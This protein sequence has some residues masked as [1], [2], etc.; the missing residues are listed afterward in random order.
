M[1]TPFSLL[2]FTTAEFKYV[3]Q[4]ERNIS[5]EAKLEI[6]AFLERITDSV[7]RGCAAFDHDHRTI[8][9][10]ETI[11]AS[12]LALTNRS[13]LGECAVSFAKEQV[14]ARDV[15]KTHSTRFRRRI[16]A[17]L[18]R[19]MRKNVPLFLLCILRYIAVDIFELACSLA[20]KQGR[21]LVRK[22]EFVDV[23][24]NDREIAS[25]AAS[26][27]LPHT[28][29]L[30]PLHFAE[31]F[32]IDEYQPVPILSQHTFREMLRNKLP[33]TKSDHPEVHKISSDACVELQLFT[34]QKVI[35]VLNLAQVI[36]TH[37]SRIRITPKD[38]LLAQSILG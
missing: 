36:A 21:V 29:G 25:L 22:A 16:V 20:A 8:L 33:H 24:R 4:G 12:F 30:L 1:T 11:E 7:I 15:N 17:L 6:S 31:E 23:I 34:E 13:E 2:Q 19:S 37:S 3:S 14:E 26:V 35:Q 10:C 32:Q 18:Q 27:G 38:L 9:R 28:F 5:K